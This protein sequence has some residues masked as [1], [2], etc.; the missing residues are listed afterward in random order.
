MFPVPLPLMLVSLLF[1]G[2]ILLGT[3]YQ[4]YIRIL[5][6]APS[7]ITRAWRDRQV[8]KQGNALQ[9]LRGCSELQL[10]RGGLVRP[11]RIY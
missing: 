8:N 4:R 3:V 1:V 5:N 10:G 2:V 9:W 11:R 6:V 7:R